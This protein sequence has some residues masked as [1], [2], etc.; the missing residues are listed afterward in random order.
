MF[1]KF[2]ELKIESLIA[3]SPATPRDSAKLCVLSRQE[4]SVTDKI[5][6]DIHEYFNAGDCLVINNTKVFPAK[7]PAF[8]PTGGKIEI[9]L[10]RPM[11]RPN[12]WTALLREYKEGLE[13]TVTGGAK[14]KITGR[15]EQGEAILEFDTDDILGYAHKH[16]LMPLPHYIEKAR[17][18]DGLSESIETD[19]ERYQTVYAK[20]EGSIAAPTAGFHFT[21]GL[22]QKLK[23]KGVSIVYITLHVGWGTFKPLKTEPEEH[24]M[25]PELAEV[26]A[27]SADIINK[28]KAAGGRV[29]STGTTSTRTLESFTDEHGLMTSGSKWTNLFIYPGYKFKMADCLI[30]NFHFPDST[31]LCLVSSFAGEDFV[32]EAYTH[33]VEKGYRFYSFGD[34]MLVL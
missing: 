23:D 30:T 26:S 33:A 20:Y 8:K 4:H 3:R 5:F 6:R 10:V 31:P 22:L 29:F 24:E 16:G 2:K 28:A 15:T 11:E 34:S 21:E 14:A 17:K 32:Y 19:K 7:L 12:V 25:L 13:L 1:E 18:H 27:E 9:L